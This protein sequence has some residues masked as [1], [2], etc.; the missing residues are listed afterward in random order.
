[1]L[2]IDEIGV[3]RYQKLFESFGYFL[4]LYIKMLLLCNWSIC[5]LLRSMTLL[6]FFSTND[7]ILVYRIARIN[8]FLKWRS[9]NFAFLTTYYIFHLTDLN[10][11]LV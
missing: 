11:T 5:D 8:L 2:D 1:M 7:I 6:L 4:P 3:T 10:D 9:S